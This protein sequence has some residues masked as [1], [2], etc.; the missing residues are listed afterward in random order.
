METVL[1]VVLNH[2]FTFLSFALKNSST[3]LYNFC[4]SLK[5][6]MNTN[7]CLSLMV[8]NNAFLLFNIVTCFNI[9]KGKK[10]RGSRFLEALIHQQLPLRHWNGEKESKNEMCGNVFNIGTICTIVTRL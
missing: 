10:N 1:F 9:R 5:H 2:F 7:D 8:V 6:V 4:P 3:Q